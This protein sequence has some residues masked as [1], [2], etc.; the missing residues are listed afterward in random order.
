[1]SATD[2]STPAARRRAWVDP[3]RI[4][5]RA[6]RVGGLP[7][8]NAVG[9]RLGFAD[10]VAR[11]LDP[12]D[13]RCALAADRVITVLVANLALG[14]QPLYGLG[15]WA[16]GWDPALLG[17]DAAQVGLLNDDRV[18]RALDELFTAD[19]ASLVTALGLAAVR[20][21]GI[22]CCEL[23]NDSTSLTLYGA[24]HAADGS[25]RGG[26]TPARPARGHSK[27]HRPDLKQ[28]VW[29]LTTAADGAV[30]ITYRLADGNT[31]DSTTHIAT[32]DALAAM[33]GRADFLYVAD[34]KLA[35]RD[36]MAHIHTRGGR[37][38]TVLPRS[39]KE[40]ASGRAWLASG[41]IAWTEVAR[42]PGKHAADP[43]EIWWATPAPAPSQDGHRIVWVRSSAK[44]AHDA[45]AR[46]ARIDAATAALAALQAKLASPRCK[47]TKL[48]AV[49][50]AARAALDGAGAGRWAHVDVHDDITPEYR[51]E[52]RGRPGRNT[53][54]RR[55]DR[56][57]FRLSWTIDAGRVAHDAA[58]DGCFPL[59]TNDHDLTPAELLAAYKGQPH[60][61]RRHAT[62]KGVLHAAPVEL[63]SDTRIDAF[64]F[65]LY[66]ALLVHALIER[67]LRQA[68]T[69]AGI[70]H[71]PLYHEDRTC[72][73]PTA[74][75][76]LEI[77]EPLTRTHVTHES[78]TLTVIQPA[79]TPL[80]HQLLDLLDIPTDAYTH[81]PTSPDREIRP[82]SLT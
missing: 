57:H 74:A 79:P 32:W 38:V 60:L 15:A 76:V 58:S 2:T 71:L 53:R 40:D 8:V 11:Y 3:Q 75:R 31:E 24:Y 47:L 39:R 78:H 62:L 70:R 72:K 43:P 68:M 61:E 29:V 48:T 80:Q 4:Q 22:D 77:L 64:A 82:K 33:L 1:M 17:L 25:P 37:F 45:A 63:K 35:T 7:V 10:L 69:A 28:L 52:G 44:R 66:T 5:A 16:T 42:R 13:A 14:R 21:Y 36:N 55:V 56:H 51:Q 50:D 12:P 65:C 59:I 34:C 49:Q 26:Q 54:Y 18:G 73:T 9:D 81:P 67:Q 20:A 30:P 27:D 19:R 6:E 41:P 23:H 46:A